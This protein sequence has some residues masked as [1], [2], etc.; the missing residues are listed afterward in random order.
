MQIITNLVQIL[1]LKMNKLTTYK[2]KTFAYAINCCYYGNHVH[3]WKLVCDLL[4]RVY[5]GDRVTEI[6]YFSPLNDI[7]AHNS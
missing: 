1:A 4:S 7:L 2:Y 5:F 6:H 3:K